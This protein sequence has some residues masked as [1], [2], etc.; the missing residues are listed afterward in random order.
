MGRRGPAKKP[1]AQKILEGNPGE[2]ALNKEEPD[3]EIDEKLSCPADLT[4]AGRD[5]WERIAPMLIEF[6]VIRKADIS[7]FYS[8]CRVVMDVQRFEKAVDRIFALHEK[9]KKNIS[10]F[11]LLMYNQNMCIKLRTQQR[12]YMQELGLTP[13]SRAAVKAIRP[14]GKKDAKQRE[15]QGSQPNRAAGI[16]AFT[17]KPPRSA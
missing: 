4:G 3:F 9:D 11:K 7:V 6:G 1:T 13:A 5:E 16:L 10:H 15:S 8:Y 2:K 14:H 17:Q 12:H